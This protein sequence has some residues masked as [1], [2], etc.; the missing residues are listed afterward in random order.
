[1]ICDYRNVTILYHMFSNRSLDASEI[2]YSRPQPATVINVSTGPLSPCFD[3]PSYLSLIVIQHRSPSCI[4]LPDVPVMSVIKTPI[5]EL[6][7]IKHPIL[8]AGMGYNSVHE[9]VG[10]LSI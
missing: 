7:G 3:D 2:R 5:T 9:F 1:M 10:F 6:F 8:L 4:P